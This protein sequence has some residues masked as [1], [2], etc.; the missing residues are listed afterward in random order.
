MESAFLSRL[1]TPSPI[2]HWL[3]LLFPVVVAVAGLTGMRRRHN[4]A[5]RLTILA[6]VTLCWLAL[7]LRFDDPLLSAISVLV[8][9]VLWFSLLTAWSAHVWNRFP[10]PVWAHGWVV[11]HLV[12]IGVACMVALVRALMY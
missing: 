3:L 4:G 5:L 12:T 1:L 8:S 10:S 11:S 7:P 6:L 2:M 9:T